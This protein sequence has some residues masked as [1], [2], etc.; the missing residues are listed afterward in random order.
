MNNDNPSK[1]NEFA[2]GESEN[3][4]SKGTASRR[5]FLRTSAVAGSAATVGLDL[6]VGNAAAQSD[7][8]DWKKE[9][10]RL[11][12]PWFDDVSPED[13]HSEYPRPQ[14]VREEWS[15]LNG[16]WDFV[17]KEN[18]DVSSPPTDQEL[19]EEILVPFPVESSLSGIERRDD[20]D[21]MWYRRTFSVPHSWLVPT[22]HPGNGIKN[23]PNSQRLQLRFE[24]VDWNAT[25]YVNGQHVGTHD[26][27]YDSFSF[28]VT[29]ALNSDGE[30]ELIVGVQ[31]PTD[32][33]GQPIGKQRDDPGGIFYTASSGIWQSVWM[34]PVPEAC[35]NGLN[36]TPDLS[37][38]TLRLTVEGTNTE[39]LTVKAT[40][41]E[42]SKE[43][44]T[45]TGS[46]SE[47]LELPISDPTLWS[48][49]NPFLYDLKVELVD[50]PNSN[51]HGGRTVD[52]VNSYFGMR[53][54]G[55]EEVNGTLRPTLNG[56]FMF[57]MATLDQGFWPDGIYTPP[58]DEALK[59]DLLK[60]KQ[61]GFNT[62]RKHV[63]V[64]NNRWF[65][66]ADRLGLMVWQDMPSPRL[67][68]GTNRQ[69]FKDELRAMIGEH[70]N[71][72]SVVMWVVFNEGW[73]KFN[74]TEVTR[75]VDELDPSRLVDGMS[76][77]NI[78]NC[79]PENGDVIDWHVYPGP[80]APTPTDERASV[81]GEYG[82]LGLAIEDHLW[83]EDGFS[84][85]DLESSE[86]LTNK[87]VNKSHQLRLLME[88]C[89]LSAAIYTQITDVEREINGLLTY[90]RKVIKPSVSE[91]REANQSLIERS[92]TLKENP[93]EPDEGT[94]GLEGVGYWPFNQTSGDTAPD[95]ANGYEATLVNGPT[96]SGGQSGNA[97]NFDGVDD[98]VDTGA[99]ILDVASDFSVAAW[100]KLDGKDGFQTAVSQNRDG[101]S[102]FFLQYS[103][104]D[105]RL[106]FSTPAIRAVGDES[107]E[108]GEW[109]HAV[110]VMEN[111]HGEMKLYVNGE[112]VDTVGTCIV[113][114]ADGD[115][116]I[117][118]ANFGGNQVDQWDG[119][120]DVV[121]VYDKPLTADEVS[122]LYQ[123]EN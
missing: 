80:S 23:N 65:Y 7:T 93:P 91:V 66:H 77:M 87:Y 69:E 123:S 35:I 21:Q 60:H 30:Q 29:D 95:R 122:E 16:L 99:S 32:D 111:Y 5:S 8:S 40:A 36:M 107:P 45:V 42:D 114:P 115:T 105:D 46:T 117:G 11:T 4:S 94:P 54:I 58:N 17:S 9:G 26:G 106:A 76:G 86:A 56:E 73:G 90:D 83:A 41:Y 113:Q 13:A 68:D 15:D 28:D 110:G 81:L 101:T 44:S 75:M 72:P 108:V 109:Y 31:D 62:V 102:A 39:E 20:R 82:G 18:I 120:I 2:G 79:D 100:V 14:L 74:T 43:V 50:R 88:R 96:W 33:R 49:D 78:C 71:H 63:K 37:E 57:Q 34:E 103:S 121:H 12:T 64:E 25:V 118:R 92:R 47:E 3:N 67:E 98:Y 24:A 61:M 27:G 51:A 53:S 119:Q 59:F 70:Y 84:Y 38:D 55:V 85:N 22:A 97:L 48:P 104:T 6:S 19:D 10:P 52:K 112:L 89:G 1:K 116:I